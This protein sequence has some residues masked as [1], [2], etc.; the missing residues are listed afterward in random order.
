MRFKATGNAP[1]LKQ[2]FYKARFALRVPLQ[3]RLRSR[4]I[5]ASNRFQTIIA[6][7]RKE[8]SWKSSDPLVRIA[9]RWRCRLSFTRS[10]SFST[11]MRR[12]AHRQTTPSPTSSRCAAM[13]ALPLNYLTTSLT[14]LRSRETAARQLQVRHV[15][16]SRSAYSY[17]PT[18]RLLRGVDAR[19][20]SVLCWVTLYAPALCKHS[21]TCVTLR[22]TDTSIGL[23]RLVLPAH[24]WHRPW[25][26]RVMCVPSAIAE[27]LP[28]LRFR[29]H[30]V[31]PALGLTG[32]R[33]KPM[34]V[35][36]HST[37]LCN[38]ITSLRDF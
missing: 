38:K 16:R 1:I 9:Q 8:L 27:T 30:K 15:P 31:K 20:I 28:R 29:A 13:L 37:K 3:D 32:L 35:Y 14:V 10:C 34:Y 2:Q 25:S 19:P 4:Q 5:T 7:L 11:S 18:A 24:A 6:F 17:T 33:V 36:I 22:V 21:A 26:E 23:A 12:S